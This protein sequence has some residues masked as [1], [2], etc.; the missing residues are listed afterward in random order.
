YEARGDWRALHDVYARKLALA[1]APD[2]RRPI[3]SAMAALAE[4]QGDDDRAIAAYRR[5]WDEFGADD[6][7]LAALERLY[8]RGGA[9]AQLET[10]LIERRGLASE[11]AARTALTFRLAEVR[12]R[13]ERWGEAIA[14]LAEVLEADPQ[15]AGAQAA[16]EAMTEGPSHRD[17]RLRA[18]LLLEPMARM[19]AAPA[20]LARVLAIRAE[21]A[22]EPMEAVALLHEIAWLEAH[23]LKHDDAAFAALTRALAAAPAHQPTFDALEK[24]TAE[25][26]QWERLLAAYKAVAARPLSIGEHVEVRCRLGALYRQH[27][28]DLDRALA[29]FGRVLDLAPDDARAT[30]AIDDLLAAAGR[31][32]ELAARL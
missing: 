15:H 32:N 12:R 5:L 20:R 29:T 13:L 21:H 16:L 19:V 10:V 6:D 14:L 24:L 27:L 1:G 30:R 8:G 17:Y 9:L 23:E 22:A 2:E 3:V 11:A 31:W 7:T 28:G 26:G 4:R 25:S 18:A